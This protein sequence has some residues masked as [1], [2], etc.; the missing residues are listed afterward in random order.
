MKRLAA[1]AMSFILLFETFSKKNKFQMMHK[2]NGQKIENEMF[3][4]TND[5]NF[6][7]FDIHNKHEEH[8]SFIVLFKN[9]LILFTI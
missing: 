3:Y 9:C 1:F 7:L 6:Y 8:Q 2:T 5:F 4:V